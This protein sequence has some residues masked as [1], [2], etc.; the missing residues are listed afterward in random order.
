MGKNASLLLVILF[1]LLV[2]NLDAEVKNEDKP[3]KGEWDFQL[4][5]IWEV[6]SAGDD[7]LVGTRILQV[8]DEG[9][10]C[11]NVYLLDLKYYKF[12]VFSSDGEYLSLFK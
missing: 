11:G 3:L 7:I 5:K 10:T 2:F 4:Q 6:A 12:F 8:D 9:K 1:N